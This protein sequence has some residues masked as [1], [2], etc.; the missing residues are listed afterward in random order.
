M[1]V[2]HVAD[3]HFG[4]LTHSHPDPATGIP[5]R[6][7]DQERCWSAAVD[8]AVEN[9]VDAVVVAGDIFH[10]PN[11]D[12]ESLARFTKHLRRLTCPA[13][14]VAGNH[15][16]AAHP[17]RSCVLEALEDGDWIQVA[18]S[19]GVFHLPD[20]LGAGDGLAVAALPSVSRHWLKAR[21][22]EGVRSDVDQTLVDNLVRILGSDDMKADVLALHWP[23][24]G[25]VL[26]NER[27]IAIVPEPT[28]PMAALEGPWDYVA[29]GHI[30]KAQGAV[31]SAM[32]RA[33]EAGS[34]G[35]VADDWASLV[36]SGS[37]D[38][39][40]FGEEAEPKGCLVIDL[41]SHVDPKPVWF[42]LPATRFV[43]ID[44]DTWDGKPIDVEGAIVRCQ[45]ARGPW[46]GNDAEH[47]NEVRRR[48][49]RDGARTVTFDLTSNREAVARAADIPETV[50]PLDGL[51]RWMEIRPVP[52]DDRPAVRQTAEQL[53]EG[54]R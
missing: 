34:L 44:W 14:L 9:N 52:E 50:T 45:G 36:Y 38:R 33:W 29:A 17:G 53:L 37:I 31:D 15:E 12:A 49:E 11:P 6:I 47:L 54:A 19:P 10:T 4:M 3:L 51:D 41:D 30:H 43:T 35:G 48:L 24:Q 39:M 1:T 22:P 26:G 5:S 21:T 27:D 8:I 18:T 2:L 28:I 13:L 40:N 16:R 25:S 46:S 23:I 32:G 20:V 42:D 7:L